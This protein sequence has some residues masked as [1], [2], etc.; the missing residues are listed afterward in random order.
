MSKKIAVCALLLVSCLSVL[1]SGCVPKTKYDDKTI[2]KIETAWSEGMGPAYLKY[3]SRIFDF[4]AGTVTDTRV[5]DFDNVD[6]EFLQNV[7]KDDFNNP[8]VEGT[9]NDKQAKALYNKIKSLGFLAWKDRYETNEIIYDGAPSTVNVYFTD[10]TV[11]S[12]YIYFKYP[13]H[14]DEIRAAFEDHF[15]VEFYY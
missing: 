8:K 2:A 11:K 3:Y 15:G 12:T 6:E 9:F 13:P 1:F 7:N 4:E 5:A 10:G 14:Y